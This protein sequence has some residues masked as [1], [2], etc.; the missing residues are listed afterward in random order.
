MSDTSYIGQVALGA[1]TAVSLATIF[2]GEKGGNSYSLKCVSGSI[3]LGIDNTVTAASGWPLPAGETVAVD[4][5][6][7]A[8]LWAIGGAADRIAAWVLS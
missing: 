4:G 2:A 6:A 5:Q 7:F 3:T 1:G 8:K